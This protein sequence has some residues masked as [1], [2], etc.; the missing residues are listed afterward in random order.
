MYGTIN[1]IQVSTDGSVLIQLNIQNADTVYR[2]KLLD[3]YNRLAH[4]S[5][6]NLLRDAF[7][8]KLDVH[9][10]YADNNNVISK[11]WLLA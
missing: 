4:L 3:K 2:F 5:M 8:N 1:L 11:V 10:E 7:S 6:F 9:I